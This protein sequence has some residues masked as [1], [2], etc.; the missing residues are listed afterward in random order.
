MSAL[1]AKP[2]ATAAFVDIDDATVWQARLERRSVRKDDHFDRLHE[3]I[4]NEHR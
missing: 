3:W 4:D 1:A 2:P